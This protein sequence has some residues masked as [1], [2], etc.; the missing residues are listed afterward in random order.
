MG[1][2]QN[3]LQLECEKEGSEEPKVSL[4]S[5]LLRQEIFLLLKVVLDKE[6][7]GRGNKMLSI[8]PG[9]RHLLVK[10]VNTGRKVRSTEQ[11][12][13]LQRGPIPN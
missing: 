8:C 6:K 12:L 1:E 9:F 4:E 3:E 11:L 7:E 13:H 5:R 10:V 2:S